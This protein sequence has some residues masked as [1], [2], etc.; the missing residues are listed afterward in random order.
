VTYTEEEPT[1]QSNP[2]CS[3]TPV[4]DGE[5]VIAFFGS[6]GLYCYDFQGKE[7]WHSELGKMTHMFGN[8]ASPV[9]YKDLCFVNFGPD[10]KTRLVAVN[11]TDGK[12]VWEAEPP[13]VD[14]SEQPQMQGGPGGGPGGRG[15]RGGFG[16]GMFVA[17]QV[18]KQADKNGD[19]KVTKAEFTALAEA[20]YDKLDAEKSGKLSQDQFTER[21]SQVI[22]PPEGFG[23]PGGG[24]GPPEGGGPPPGEG[25]GF[26]PGRFIG[27]G[28]FNAADA[29]KDGS[30]TR[31]ELEGTFEKWFA[32]WDSGKSGSLDEA[33]LRD[34][35]NAALPRPNFGGPGGPG[36]PGGRGGPGGGRGGPGG[37]W[38][39]PL[40]IKYDGHDEL[41]MNFP[42]RLVGYE[43][44]TGKQ[45]WLSKSLGGTIYTSPVW[46]ESSLVAMSSDM[47]GGTAIAVKAGG[48]GDVTE[49][50]RLW[51]LERLKG[52]IGSGIIYEGHLYNISQDGIA[53][54]F[55]LKSGNKVWEERLKGSGSR[56]SS[57]SSILLADGKLYVPNQSGDVFVVRA[58]PKF[59]VL[60]T[61]SVGE[62]TNASLAAS[63][64]EL[65][66]RTDKGLWCFAEAK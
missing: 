57:W 29:D 3:A 32:E 7:L 25:R 23:P 55:D 6:A 31:A 59:E 66:V 28:L 26:G 43:P 53:E 52:H 12:T 33:Q 62:P 16:P 15:G 21:L 48:K 54:C 14:P 27:P 65:F 56:G 47:G 37:S 46:G 2:Y 38:S 4:T 63:D 39:T 42:S 50:A 61:N 13:K 45:L 64:G 10:E 1:Q 19:E 5:R 35:L 36:G 34:G 17:P 44:T 51:R 20:W 9:L 30:L 22:P 8:A 24:G 18:V 41:I 49:S 11:K 40:V 58:S 60:S